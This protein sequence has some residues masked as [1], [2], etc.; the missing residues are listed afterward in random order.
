MEL[1]FVLL[2]IPIGFLIRKHFFKGEVII[3]SDFILKR[4]IDTPM[5]EIKGDVEVTMKVS[6]VEVNPLDFKDALEGVMR[7]YESVCPERYYG[8]DNVAIAED[9]IK[10]Y[11][12]G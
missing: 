10:R 6:T 11:D 8:D 3:L 1:I 12:G 4:S 7:S 2:G 5:L 9:T